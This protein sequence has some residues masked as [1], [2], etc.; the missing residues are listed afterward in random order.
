MK[1]HIVIAASAI[2]SIAVYSCNSG[3]S[4][5]GQSNT[6]ANTSKSRGQEL[7][8]QRCI[9]CHGTNGNSQMNNAANLQLTK[10]DSSGIVNT[11]KNGKGNGAMPMFGNSLNDED[12]AQVEMY[13][14]SLRK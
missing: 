6:T 4:E 3:T 9:T 11:I 5:N 2:F 10:L 12:L 1:K 7:Y 13:V 14:K 8:E